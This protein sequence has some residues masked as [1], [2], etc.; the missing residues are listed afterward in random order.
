[1]HNTVIIGNSQPLAA[2]GQGTW[3]MGEQASQR[4]CEVSA[5]QAGIDCGLSLIDCAEM[6][7]DG[8][9]ERV[10]GQAI[11]GRRENV[12]L[13]SKVYPWNAGGQALVK[14]CEGSL[15]RLGTDYLDLYL[16]HWPGDIPLGETVAGMASLMAAGKIG[17]WGVSNFDTT[18]LQQLWQVPGGR[19]C[20]TNQV[21]YHLASRGIEYDLLPWCRQQGVP[22]MAYSPLAQAGR[23]RQGLLNHPVLVALARARGITVAQLLLAW[24]IREPGVMAIPK[25]GTVGHVQQNADVLQVVLREDELQAINAAFPAPGE[26]MRLDMV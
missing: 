26:K 4:A 2:I 3:Y 5:L 7:A 9:A 15:R 20:A 11:V 25:A 14:A 10:V 19:A 8:E 21:L 17:Q 18:D 16:L 24:V 12:Y 6:Y 23:L 22:V 1:M 13:V